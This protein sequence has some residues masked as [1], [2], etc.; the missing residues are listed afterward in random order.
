MHMA[1]PMTADDLLPLIATLAPRERVRL[2][3]LI[4]EQRGDEAAIYAAVPP[5]KDEF[6][7]DEEPLAWEAEGWETQG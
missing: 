4:T 2:M 6:S 5:Q 1:K 3:R 7:A